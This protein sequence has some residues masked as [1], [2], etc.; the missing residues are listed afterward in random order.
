MRLSTKKKILYGKKYKSLLVGVTDKGNSSITGWNPTMQGTTARAA[1]PEKVRKQ[2]TTG[3]YE[4]V[5]EETKNNIVWFK[6]V[7]VAL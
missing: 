1:S 3:R 2:F 7:K 5:S 4:I 6:L